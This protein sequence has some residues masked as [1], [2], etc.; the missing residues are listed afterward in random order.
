MSTTTSSIASILNSLVEICKDGEQGFRAAADG[1]KDADL[2][3]FFHESSVQR[4]QFKNE[5]QVLVNSLGEET[6]HSG[7][8]AGS[9]HRGWIDIRAA[10]THGDEHAILE[11]CERGEDSAVAEYRDALGHEELPVEIR[12]VIA[13]QYPAVQASH[14]RVKALRDRTAE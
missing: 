11:E 5:L 12:N 3:T 1:V 9:L 8:I 6:E 7:S 2:K 4:G 14:D 13:R 10:M